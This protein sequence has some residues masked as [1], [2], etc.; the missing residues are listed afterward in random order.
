[1]PAGD[2][3]ATL[4]LGDINARLKHISV[5]AEGLRSLGFEP[6]ARDKRAVLYTERQF[7]AICDS[8][9]QCVQEAQRRALQAA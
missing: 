7:W 3:Q 2:E 6:A 4:K 5:T 8:I 9:A 1:M